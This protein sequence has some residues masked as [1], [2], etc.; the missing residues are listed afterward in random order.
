MEKCV[1]QERPKADALNAQ[2]SRLPS[3]QTHGLCMTASVGHWMAGDGKVCIQSYK[4]VGASG[5]SRSQ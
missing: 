2:A 5:T 4:Y 3:M 1:H